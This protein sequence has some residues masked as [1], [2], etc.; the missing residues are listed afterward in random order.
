[1]IIDFHAHIS[2]G[3]TD[4]RDAEIQTLAD[5]KKSMAELGITH[6]VVFPF[7]GDAKTLID[8]S[9]TLLNDATDDCFYPF[10]RIDPNFTTESELRD[11]LQKGFYGLKLHPEAQKF[12]PDDDR[13]SWIYDVCKEL[14]KPVLFHTSIS[15]R[16][17]KPE[18]MLKVAYANPSVNFILAHYLGGSFQLMKDVCNYDNVYTDTSIKSSCYTLKRLTSLGYDRIIFGSDA[19]Y[20]HQ[21]VELEKVNRSELDSA[22][23]QKILCD[24]AKTV[25]G[26][27]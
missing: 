23:N 19:P 7:S 12:Y 26:L 10:L 17:S 5:L 8:N 15:S 18:F 16:F 27:K 2:F 25:L 4:N 20:N 6:S 11:L 3:N 21:A 9:L 13:F 22:T 14:K 1:M 24:N